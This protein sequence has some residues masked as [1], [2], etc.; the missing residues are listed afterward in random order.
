MQLEGG[1]VWDGD[2]DSNLKILNLD[3]NFVEEEKR[4]LLIHLLESDV[5]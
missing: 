4:R 3:L 1:E 2:D 5:C